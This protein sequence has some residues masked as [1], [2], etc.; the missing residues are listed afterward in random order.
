MALFSIAEAAD[1]AFLKS[2]AMPISHDANVMTEH[3]DIII[4]TALS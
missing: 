3:V 2:T 4:S 1:Y